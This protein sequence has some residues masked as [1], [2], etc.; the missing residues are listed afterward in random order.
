VVV[1]EAASDGWA[2][3]APARHLLVSLIALSELAEVSTTPRVQCAPVGDGRSVEATARD[4]A[5]ALAAQSFKAV[6][7][8]G[9]DAATGTHLRPL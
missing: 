6:R 4:E 3:G 5:D 2:Q 9:K 1:V 8:A 7:A